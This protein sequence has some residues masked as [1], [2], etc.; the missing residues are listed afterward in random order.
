MRRL[1]SFLNDNEL[2]LRNAFRLVT[3]A[4]LI[5]LIIRVE[6]A[7]SWADA[8]HDKAYEASDYASTAAEQAE[9]AADKAEEAVDECAATRWR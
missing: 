9:K 3:L 5:V 4:L 6:D 7:I 2:I 8:A 1:A